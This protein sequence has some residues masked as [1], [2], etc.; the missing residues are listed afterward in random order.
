MG[1][2]GVYAP[3]SVLA[4]EAPLRRADMAYLKSRPLGVKS[5]VVPSSQQV[6]P[7]MCLGESQPHATK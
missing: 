1:S 6:W 5:M 7:L 2:R 3:D 4:G